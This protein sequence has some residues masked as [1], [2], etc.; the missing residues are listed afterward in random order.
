MRATKENS[1]RSASLKPLFLF[2]L[3]ILHIRL[4]GFNTEQADTSRINSLTKE[5]Y[6]SAQKDPSHAIKIAH[7]ALEF[8]KIQGYQ[9]GIAD[10][11]LALGA[12]FM[13]KYNPGDSA[14]YYYQK[15]LNIYS[16]M[17]DFAGQG[18]ACYGLSFLYNFK[19]DQPKSE[20]FGALSVKYFKKAGDEKGTIAALGTIIFLAKQ[21]GDYE[22]ALDLSKEAIETARSIN[23]T[24]QWANALNDQGQ[25]YKDMFLFNQS[26]DSYFAAYKLW[27]EKNDSSGLAIAYG[28]IAN[29]Y[30]YQEDYQKSLDFNFKKLHIIQETD[31]LWEWNKT[32]NNIALAYS[33]LNKHDSALSYMQKGLQLVEKRN[34]PNGVAN[35]CDKMASTFLRM[36]EVDSAFV[37]S[38]RAVAIS[39][40][41]NNKTHASY[42]VTFASVL[43]KKNKYN[44]ALTI[45]KEAY[46]LAEKNPDSHTQLA[47]AFLLSE[48]YYH[49]NRKGMAYTFLTEY[50]KLNDS[51]TNR[52]YMRKVTRLDLQYEYDKKQ[53]AAQHE[54]EMLD[55]T[56]QLKTERLRKSWIVIIAV[57]LLSSAGA[58]IS[59]L[60]I[61]NKNHRID[62]MSFEIRNYLLRLEVIH[63]KKPNEATT[64]ETSFHYLVENYGL[65]QREAEIM[66]LIE[67][68]IGNE[69]I[70]EK[71]FVS[72][73]TIK[74]HIKNIFIKLD[75]RNR[76]QALHKMTM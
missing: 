73:N 16:L 13:A 68:G 14:I 70:A 66:E 71:L 35:S 9:K 25:V 37:Y 43:D 17:N 27:K 49:L 45:A 54:I 55:K 74:F 10:A 38:S 39:K 36:G 31:K 26:I 22:K 12:A 1:F 3:I 4:F 52:E 47:A 44:D 51:I 23:D 64:S 6:N 42:L 32:L 58:I 46:H 8:S 61:R 2:F 29:A 7:A 69:E 67:T 75:V 53:K 20:E 59:F 48:I 40:K 63:K 57:F 76:V 62:Q 50:L 56:N 33:N 72:R 30:F 21:A 5:A 65:T 15:S 34:Y 18:S 24:L 60:V 19:S 28:S 11:S 41:T